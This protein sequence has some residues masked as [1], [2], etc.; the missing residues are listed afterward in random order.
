MEAEYF[1]GKKVYEATPYFG[2][3]LHHVTQVKCTMIT[4]RVEPN[5]KIISRNWEWNK[6]VFDNNPPDIHFDSRIRPAISISGSP[7]QYPEKVHRRMSEW[8]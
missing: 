5:S 4:A 1:L 6:I 3:I 2:P 8:H 7:K